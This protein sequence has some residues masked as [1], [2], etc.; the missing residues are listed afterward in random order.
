M[1]VPFHV[2]FDFS[3]SQRGPFD[4]RGLATP[5]DG[6]TPLIE[7]PIRMVSIDTPEKS[8]GG[9][10]ALGQQKLDACRARLESGFYDGLVPEETKAYLRD[11]LT[12]DAGLRHIEAASQ[13]SAAFQRFMDE[14]LQIDDDTRRRLAVFPTGEL[15]DIYG[16]LLAYIAPWFKREEL[17]EFGNGEED[18]QS[19]DAGDGL[20]RVVRHLPVATATARFPAGG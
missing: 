7:Q 19:A 11:R 13:A 20:G 17:P 12:P 1:P 14:R 18:V 9:G 8:Y 2:D 3:P 16:R 15:M 6:D 4:Q 10:E 5:S